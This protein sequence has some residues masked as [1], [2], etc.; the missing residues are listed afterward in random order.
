M[1]FNLVLNGIQ[2]M[3]G[4]IEGEVTITAGP[5]PTRQRE[6]E[7]GR[8]GD[9]P[10]PP[11]SPVGTPLPQKGEA[12]RV[13][14]TLSP[15]LSVGEGLEKTPGDEGLPPLS[16]SPTRPIG[17]GGWVEVVVS[18]TGPGIPDDVLPRIFE[19]FYTTKTSGTG[20]GLAIVKR[21]VER[22]GGTIEVTSGHREGRGTVFI[23]RLRGGGDEPE[24]PD[25]G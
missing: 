9:R 14:N 18:D 12:K 17:R 24:N 4:E 11:L 15:V 2:A 16:H 13:K 21:D 6:W 5:C 8:V 10:S 1:F 19:P 25:R 20:L 23:V 3:E 7:S 22:M